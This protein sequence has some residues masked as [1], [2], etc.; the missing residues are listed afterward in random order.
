MHT[1]VLMHRL[2]NVKKCSVWPLR[3]RADFVFHTFPYDIPQIDPHKAIRLGLGGPPLSIDDADKSLFV[4]DATWRLAKK[5]EEPFLHLPVRSLGV[6]QTAYPRVARGDT[7]P[8]QGLA[9][10]EAIYCAYIQLGWSTE[11]LLEH[12]RWKD[13]FLQ[14]NRLTKRDSGT[15]G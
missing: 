15:A 14:K 3:H 1:I 11:G 10:I 12:Y 6:Y 9:T 7:D 4:L 13:S 8:D 5:M 2:E